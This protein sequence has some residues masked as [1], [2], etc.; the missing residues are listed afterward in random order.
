MIRIYG[1]KVLEK[2]ASPVIK[3]DAK[4]EELAKAMLDTLHKTGYG[5][6]LAAPQV[7]KSVRLIVIDLKDAFPDES[8]VL[9]GKIIPMPLLFHLI[10][11]NPSITPIG[12][13]K[14]IQEEGCLSIPDRR[15]EVERFSNV[16]VRYQDLQGEWNEIQCGGFLARCLQHE[17][18]HLDGILILHRALKKH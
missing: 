3:F 17:T 11:V 18:D 15:I 1:D 5:V 16:Q 7:G 4:L 10:I 12:T 13:E 6:G 9:N 14:D 2:V 8:V